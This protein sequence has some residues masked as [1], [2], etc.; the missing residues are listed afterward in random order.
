M[1]R[2]YGD[3]ELAFAV[4]LL[5]PGQASRGYAGASSILPSGV[6]RVS[7]P[8]AERAAGAFLS[9]LMLVIADVAGH[10][11]FD[12]SRPRG[13][14]GFSRGSSHSSRSGWSLLTRHHGLFN[15]HPL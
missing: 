6:G 4:E 5:D 11:S 2:G 14:G 3:M 1:T 13:G 12:A 10:L 7:K 9:G 8:A 15:K